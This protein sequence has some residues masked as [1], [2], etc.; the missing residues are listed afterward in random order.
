MNRVSIRQRVVNLVPI[1]V[2]AAVIVAGG[3]AIFKSFFPPPVP[4]TSGASLVR[5][6]LAAAVGRSA[7]A[8]A[9]GGIYA[10]EIDGKDIYLPGVAVFLE[11]P[12]TGKRSDEVRTDLSGRFTVQVPGQSRYRLCWKSK[13]YGDGCLQDLISAGREPL[14][15]STVL[16][17]LPT[18]DGFAASFGKVRL[19][20]E[21]AGY[22]GRSVW[23][24][25]AAVGSIMVPRLRIIGV[26]HDDRQ[27]CLTTVA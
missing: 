3:C 26:K 15:L 18:K 11:D 20:D 12:Q 19:E 6:Y 27:S 24:R 16:I 14:F 8:E 2:V 17:R 4:K 13:V 1:L 25:A 21:V 23:R 22:Q 5:G 10:R 7:R 9:S